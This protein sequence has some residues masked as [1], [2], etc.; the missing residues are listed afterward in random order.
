MYVENKDVKE[1]NVK[2]SNLMK[3]EKELSPPP[4]G[5]HIKVGTAHAKDGIA[6]ITD[7]HKDYNGTLV[8]YTWTKPNGQEGYE[9]ARMSDVD[10][11]EQLYDKIKQEVQSQSGY[12]NI[13]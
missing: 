10:S 4:K 1:G 2:L 7:H 9:E 11:L 8:G 5:T 6:T 13:Q 12:R 3:G